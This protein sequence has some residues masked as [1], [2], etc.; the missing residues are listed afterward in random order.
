VLWGGDVAR[1][2]GGD[3]DTAA[4]QAL[5]AKIGRDERVDATLLPIGDGLMIARKR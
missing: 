5:N 3:A 1:D 4:L 2:A